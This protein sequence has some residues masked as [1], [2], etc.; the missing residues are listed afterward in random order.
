MADIEVTL[1]SK[2]VSG[3]GCWYSRLRAALF[4]RFFELAKPGV[5][6]TSAIHVLRLL[7]DAWLR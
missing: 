7:I 3:N 2:S 4:R 1:V 6:A 5:P